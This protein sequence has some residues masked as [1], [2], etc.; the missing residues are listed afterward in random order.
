MLEFAPSANSLGN[1]KQ[2]ERPFRGTFYAVVAEEYPTYEILSITGNATH[3][4]NVEGS[5]M[6]FYRPT[7][8]SPPYITGVLRAANGDCITFY[9]YPTMVITDPDKLSGTLGGKMYMVGGT[10]R[11]S[12]CQ[13]EVDMQGVFS[14]SEDYAMWTAVGTI[15]Y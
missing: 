12:G 13:G 2:V 8:S 15:N 14:M 9:S 3:L 7:V 11:F 6:T 4:G 5:T 1:G 10:G